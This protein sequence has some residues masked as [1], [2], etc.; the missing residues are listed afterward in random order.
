MAIIN[1]SLII[2]VSFV[3]L[4]IVIAVPVAK[5]IHVWSLVVVAWRLI[6]GDWSLV[7]IRV[8]VIDRAIWTRSK[9]WSHIG[10][11][12]FYIPS[13]LNLSCFCCS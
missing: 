2:A 4:I 8:V 10:S 5:L 13:N 1:N 11:I 7:K 6:G 3:E 12:I 9:M